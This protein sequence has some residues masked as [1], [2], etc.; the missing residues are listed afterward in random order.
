MNCFFQDLLAVL[1]LYNEKLE[2]SNTFKSLSKAIPK[3]AYVDL[4]VYDNSP[5]THNLEN[6]ESISFKIHYIH[7]EMNSG[8]SAAYNYGA[9]FAETENKTWMLIL[10]QDTTFRNNIFNSYHEAIE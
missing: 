5:E 3:G 9:K 4:V 6:V 1:V 8:V 7:D 10:D 2:N